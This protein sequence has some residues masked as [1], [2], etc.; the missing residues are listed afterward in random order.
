MTRESLDEAAVEKLDIEIVPGSIG[1]NS[2]QQILNSIEVIDNDEVIMHTI[3]SS[4]KLMSEKQPN[5]VS[6]TSRSIGRSTK[7][8]QRVL[9][10]NDKQKM[11]KW[12]DMLAEYFGEGMQGFNEMR[13]LR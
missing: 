3:E 5:S 13:S 4:N 2:E 9:E 11:A 1:V 12:E 7:F 6:G 8:N 10:I